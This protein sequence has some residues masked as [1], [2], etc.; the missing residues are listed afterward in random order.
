MM[1]VTPQIHDSKWPSYCSS[2]EFA[3]MPKDNAV[4]LIFCLAVS[5]AFDMADPVVLLLYLS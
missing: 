3:L 2:L 4:Q 5:S 1:I